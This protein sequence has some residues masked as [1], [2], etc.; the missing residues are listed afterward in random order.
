MGSF[1]L[2]PL[3]ARGKERP[4]PVNVSPGRLQGRSQCFGKGI[5]LL[6]IHIIETVFLG[7]PT[8]SLV[9]V[10]NYLSPLHSLT[11]T[12]QKLITALSIRYASTAI[13]VVA[14]LHLSILEF[15]KV[16]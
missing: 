6:L 16:I 3:Y 15:H 12:A 9:T 5:N 8:I 14:A 10:P 7:N 1:T 11:L 2:R 13:S 4:R